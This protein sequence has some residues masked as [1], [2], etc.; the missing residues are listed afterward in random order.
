MGLL[1]NLNIIARGRTGTL[2]LENKAYLLLLLLNIYLDN[3]VDLFDSN[4]SNPTPKLLRAYGILNNNSY[5]TL[6]NES[7]LIK[8]LNRFDKNIVQYLRFQILYTIKKMIQVYLY[9]LPKTNKVNTIWQPISKK[10]L[11]DDDLRLQSCN[12]RS[13]M[14]DMGL[15]STFDTSSLNLQPI[16]QELF[17]YISSTDDLVYNDNLFKRIVYL[18][19]NFIYINLLYKL[20]SQCGKNRHSN[21]NDSNNLLNMYLDYHDFEDFIKRVLTKV[22]NSKYS[23]IIIACNKILS[24]GYFDRDVI[25]LFTQPKLIPFAGILC[26]NEINFNANENRLLLLDILLMAQVAE[27]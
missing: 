6:S 9:D 11:S 27:R 3:V 1:H 8:L 19:K 25:F 14:M 26:N 18:T 5:L 21:N 24:F 20:S 4:Y 12:L 23:D 17:Q 7:I 13:M 22:G 16:V 10:K 15:T 2:T